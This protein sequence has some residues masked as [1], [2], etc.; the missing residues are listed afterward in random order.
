MTPTDRAELTLEE[1]VVRVDYMRAHR[2][3]GDG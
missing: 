2:G 3:A 1:Y